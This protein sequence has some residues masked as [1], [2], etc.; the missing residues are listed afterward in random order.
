MP[1]E[2]AEEYAGK[3]EEA[4]EGQL[5]PG[6]EF[7]FYLAVQKA[8]GGEVNVADIYAAALE[9]PEVDTVE[10]LVRVMIGGVERR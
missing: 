8:L 7:E 10:G 6:H 5:T 9:H 3:G 2:Q 1:V 4:V